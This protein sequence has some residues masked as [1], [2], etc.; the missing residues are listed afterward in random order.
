MDKQTH[1]SKKAVTPELLLPAGNMETF[2]AAIAGGADAV[3]L[4]IKNFNARGRAQNFTWKQL[5]IALAIAKKHKA[6]IYITLNT[7]IKNTEIEELV[8]TLHTLNQ[9]KPD[10]VIIQDWGVYFLIKKF[11]PDI[12]VHGSTQMGIHNSQ[13]VNYAADNHFERVILARELTMEELKAIVQ[14]S[15]T[16]TELF[17][18]GALCYS[19]SGMCLYSSFIGGQGANRGLCKQPC[20][21]VF[22]QNKQSTFPFS[23]KDLETIELIPQIK[24]LGINSLKIEGRLKSANYVYTVAKAYK[25]VLQDPNNVSNAKEM[26]KMDMGRDKTSYFLGEKITNAITDRTATGFDL[27]YVKHVGHDFLRLQTTLDIHKGDRIRVVHKNGTQTAFKIS[28]FDVSD[29]TYTIKQ[30]P[31]APFANKDKVYLASRKDVKL[32]TPEEPDI[33]LKINP[34]P[35]QLKKQVLESISSVKQNKKGQKQ[36]S[37]YVRINNIDWIKKVNFND[38]SGLI[39]QL[40]LDKIDQLK[41]NV[42]FIRK[43]ID[44]IIIELPAFIPEKQIGN[45]QSAINKQKGKGIKKFMISHLSQQ[46]FFHPKDYIIANENIYTFN[47]AAISLLHDKKIANFTYPLENDKENLKDYN[48]KNGI[49]PVYFK[50]KLF[51]SRMPVKLDTKK[52]LHDDYNLSLEYTKQNNLN[53]IYPQDPV[54]FT[55][56]TDTLFKQGFTK[57]LIDFSFE[58]PSSNRWK[59][60]LKRTKFSEQIQ[61]AYSFNLKKGLI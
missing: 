34:T 40:P 35:S 43:N 54:S 47:D 31:E 46:A 28:E 58:K 57:F 37:F 11:F 5:A 61:P 12:P 17:I 50:P 45:W 7:V 22:H 19:F 10:A 27:G 1:H 21:R 60:V 24:K 9:I 8:D 38:I 52:I 48:H 26:L 59:T 39:I 44:K 51:F 20:R 3:Y 13:G 55:H 15:R 41:T 36:K 16:E 32:T 33:E 42:P 29:N 4:G 23:L 14:K 49:V 6:K 30:I 53:Y 25:S 18:H 2:K 56:Y